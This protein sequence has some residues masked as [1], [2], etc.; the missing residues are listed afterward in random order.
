MGIIS[1]IVIILFPLN[2]EKCI[3]RIPQK[4]QIS[5]ASDSISDKWA[6]YGIGALASLPLIGIDSIGPGYFEI[7][8]NTSLYK[9]Y[10]TIAGNHQT[11]LRIRQPSF[12]MI[13]SLAAFWDSKL[14][15]S[16]DH[17]IE[18]WNSP[19]FLQQQNISS[20]QLPCLVLPET[21][22]VYWTISAESLTKKMLDANQAFWTKQRKEQAAQLGLD[23]QQV[24][25]LASI[26]QEESNIPSEQ[27]KIAGVYHNRLKRSMRLQA[28][29][30]V[31]FALQD[32]T[33]KRVLFEHLKYD[34]PWNTYLYSGLP[35]GPINIPEKNAIDQ[36]LQLELHN[37]LYF[38]AKPDFSGQHNFT[39]SYT[40]HLLNAREY[41]KAL[42]SLIDSPK[43]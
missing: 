37:Y 14:L 6:K 39:E 18:Y 24:C 12:R 36:V 35:P 25:V 16:S 30:T 22:E 5:L 40:Q 27:R 11:P 4:S 33:L 8:A 20:D 41:Q 15:L 23:I 42:T 29:P 3:V 43:Y 31:K 38:C 17:L 21:Y 32:F 26:I 34:S 9:W 10:R 1:G 2:S 7:Q 19:A 13:E 28:D